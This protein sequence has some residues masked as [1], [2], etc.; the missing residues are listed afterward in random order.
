MMNEKKTPMCHG[1]PSRTIDADDAT[2][3]FDLAHH[4]LLKHALSRAKGLRV[5]KRIIDFR[6]KIT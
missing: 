5:T 3:W 2:R 4:K 1:E 6:N